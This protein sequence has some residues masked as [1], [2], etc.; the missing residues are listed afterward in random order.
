MKKLY[1]LFI[2]II[3]ANAAVAQAPLGIPYQAIARNSSGTIVASHAISL[4]FS[5]HDSA[6]TGTVVY[7]ETFSPTTNALGLFNVNIG[8][9]TIVSGTFNSIT[10][11]H[12]AKYM[13]VEMD[14]TGG[15]S[16]TDMGTTQM[17]SVPY[18]I[19][20]NS[21]GSVGG[22][23]SNANTLLYTTDGF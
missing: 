9:G 23:G 3:A 4:R 2:S 12:N 13:Q 10:W 8:T 16:Y 22:S 15:S 11:S 18:A 19:F 5:I 21:A 7:Q 17:M 20:S 6:S 1:L 14:A